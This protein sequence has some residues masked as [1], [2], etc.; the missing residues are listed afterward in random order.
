MKKFLIKNRKNTLC[1]FQ[2]ARS[3]PSE[4]ICFNICKKRP[5]RKSLFGSSYVCEPVKLKGPIKRERLAL[6]PEPYLTSCVDD[7]CKIE[8]LK[9]RIR[10]T[11]TAITT[12]IFALVASFLLFVLS[13]LGFMTLPDKLVCYIGVS[14]LG[15][16]MTTVL[17]V[18][19]HQVQSV[20]NN[21]RKKP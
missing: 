11:W 3:Q 7:I 4:N 1:P 14:T 6:H 20:P 12:M 21:F 19:K 8:N 16:I 15:S 2:A 13:G 17:I 18:F 10:I 9:N 5:V